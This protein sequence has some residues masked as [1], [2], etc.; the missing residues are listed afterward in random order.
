[1]HMHGGPTIAR[2]LAAIAAVL[3][4]FLS[5]CE[6]R[7]PLVTLRFLDRLSSGSRGMQPRTVAL[8]TGICTN[9]GVQLT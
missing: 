1:M 3:P 8:G 5:V 7:N 4:G 2:R 9:C 6:V